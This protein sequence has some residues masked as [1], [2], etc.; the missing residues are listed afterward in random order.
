MQNNTI[1]TLQE[2]KNSEQFISLMKIRRNL[3]L[4]LIVLLIICGTII[5]KFVEHWSWINAFYFVVSTSATVGLGDIVPQTNAGKII[6][7]VYILTMVPIILYCF[8]IIAQLYFNSRSFRV[9]E[10]KTNSK[11][12]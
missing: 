12:Q 5:F 7:S 10:R 1:E 8:T 3:A 9:H 2:L 11:K 4:G 6:T